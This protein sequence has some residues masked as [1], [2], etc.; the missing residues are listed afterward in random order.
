M[1]SSSTPLLRRAL[2]WSGV[3][4]AA[5]ALVCGGIGFAVAGGTGALNGVLG[6]VIAVL[7]TGVTALSILIANRYAES[8]LYQ[9]VFFAV[10]MGGW[11]L[12]LVLFVL[13]LWLVRG[14]PWLAPGVFF[15]SLVAGIVLSL[16]IDVMVVRGSKLPYV[17]D[18][19]LPSQS[20][21]T[22]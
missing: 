9:A 20:H 5:L 16:A 15:L 2:R 1:T 10:V 14:A 8:E 11:L 18:A 13:V 3:I 12:K 21:D 19:K 4:G 17:S 22:V 7:F 6:V